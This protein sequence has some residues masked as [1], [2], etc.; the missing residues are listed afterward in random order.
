MKRYF[1][2]L[3]IVFSLLNIHGI[4]AQ[5]PEFISNWTSGTAYLMPQGRWEVGLF[6]PLR[7][8]WK[9]NLEIET[10]PLTD[11]LMPNVAAKWGHFQ[12]GNLAI[13]TRHCIQSP[14]LLLR[15]IAR[16]GT[17][18]IISPEFD[19]PFMIS[20][21]NEVLVSRTLTPDFLVTL[22]AGV[23]VALKGGS[24]DE[25]TT[26]DLPLIFPRMAVFYHDV[27]TCFGSDLHGRIFHRWKFL[28]DGDLFFVP[29]SDEQ[30]AFEHKG[31]IMWDKSAA[32]QLCFGYKLVYG[33]YPF[34]TQWHL[35]APLFDFQWA[36]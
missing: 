21:N 20:S 36:W 16:E 7:Y 10:H 34:G 23:A 11:I 33:E 2:M 24:L 5:A 35:F 4:L 27:A 14:T 25:R 6:Q 22:K 32:F 12:S 30:M 31:M 26:I 1:V 8:A 3:L 19:I 29:T 13:A 9:E 17:G 15:V 28:V 18:G